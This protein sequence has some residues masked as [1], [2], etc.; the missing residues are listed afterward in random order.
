[1]K[2]F[3][4]A[5]T[6]DVIFCDNHLLVATKPCGWLTQPNGEGCP[7][8]ETFAKAWVKR[9]FD[10]PGAVFLHC[11]HRLDRPVFGLVLFAK[12]SKALSRL[13]EFSRDGKIHRMY[14]AEVEGILSQSQGTLE[15][16]LIH[17]EHRAL[18]A[19]ES[20][21][22]AKRAVLHYTVVSIQEHSTIVK[23]E[24]Q[25]GRY[26]QIRAQFS[27]IGHPIIGDAKY[28]ASKDLGDTIHLACTDLKFP[29]PVTREAID[30]HTEAPFA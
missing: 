29:H 13:N 5:Q 14:V 20:E 1:M 10:K 15:H 28:G 12:T 7:D 23:V 16:F 22:D 26:H 18:L 3:G 19:K 24:L 11:I 21:R 8:L 27:A 9:E 6:P 2:L 25:T 4:N 17:G 30:L